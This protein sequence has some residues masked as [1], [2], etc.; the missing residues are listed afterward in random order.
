MVCALGMV[1]GVLWKVGV[2]MTYWTCTCKAV[3]SA[4]CK[5]CPKCGAGKPEYAPVVSK[6]ETPA[7]RSQ[8][9]ADSPTI[10]AKDWPRVDQRSLKIA[11]RFGVDRKD[12][13]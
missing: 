6:K 2:K 9:M 4:G 7:R 11:R 1:P 8:K 10:P 3:N 5:T 13:E 12:G